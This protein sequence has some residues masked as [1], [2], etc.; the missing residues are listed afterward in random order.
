ME[1]FIIRDYNVQSYIIVAFFVCLLLDLIVIHKGVCV[2][3]YFLLAC[4]HIISSNIKFFSKNYNKKLSFK[5]YYYTSMTFMFIFIILLINSILRFR[6][7]FLDE[8]LFLIL[9]F[10]I[11]GT[12]VLAI[13]YYIICGDD[14]REIKLN[15]NIENH[16]NS[17]QPH[18][19]LR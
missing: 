3:V 15:R 16:E 19:H 14:Y 11:F 10:G 2:L 8:F 18:A 7:D 12:P 1:K 9:Y 5:I 6:Y 4:H 13:V 17:Q